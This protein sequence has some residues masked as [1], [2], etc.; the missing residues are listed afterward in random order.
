MNDGGANAAKKSV[1]G[2]LSMFAERNLS[3]VSP[4]LPSKR[5]GLAIVKEVPKGCQAASA[6]VLISTA[7][8]YRME[9]I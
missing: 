3:Q 7:C 2:C 4:K 9:S 8:K 6:K 1:S 5:V